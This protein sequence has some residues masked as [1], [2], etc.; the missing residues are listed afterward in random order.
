MMED[1][2][3]TTAMG[4]QEFLDAMAR[5]K[6]VDPTMALLLNA[7]KSTAKGGI[8]KLRQRSRGQ[9]P[10]YEPWPALKRERRRPDIRVVVLSTVRIGIHRKLI[11]S[12]TGNRHGSESFTPYR[13]PSTRL[14]DTALPH[15]AR[16]PG[17][18]NRHRFR[19]S[20]EADVRRFRASAGLLPPPA[21]RWAA[22]VSRW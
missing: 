14:S 3:I 18:D 1:L 16:F 20:A 2:G 7:I 17:R 5:H 19:L 4:G 8:G 9:V 10:Y 11:C 6:Q 21:L 22:E 15:G 13:Q 12:V